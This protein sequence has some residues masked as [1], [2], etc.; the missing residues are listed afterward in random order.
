MIILDTNV[1]SEAMQPRPAEPVMR[2][3]K[4]APGDQLYT[5]AITEAEMRHGA[6][7]CP[8]LKRR[9][10]RSDIVERIFSIRFAGHILPFDSAAARYFPEVLMGMKRDRSTHSHS[11]AQIAAIAISVGAIVATRNVDD[12]ERSGATLVNPWTA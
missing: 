5:T 10:E 11:D 8:I 7:S 12:F 2:W 1:I 3:L 9:K 6:A 4:F